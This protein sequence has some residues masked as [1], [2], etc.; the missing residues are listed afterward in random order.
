MKVPFV[1]LAAQYRELAPEIDEAISR[2]IRTSDFVLGKELLQFEEEFAEYCGV[3][4]AIGVDSGISALELSLRALDV[5]PGDEVITAANSFVA[6][7]SPITMVGA[8]PVL[9]DIDPR[10]YNLN[11]NTVV[12]A[13]TPKTKAIIPV[14]LYG[15]P[16][17]ID[18]LIKLAQ[19]RGIAIVEDACQA[20]GARYKG[21]RVGSLGNAAAFS[22]Y[23]AKNLGAY[24]D[25]GMIV[26][27]DSAVAEKVGMLRNYGQKVKY[28][29]ELIAFNHR[30]DTIQAAVLRVKLRHLDD[31][32]AARRRSAALYTQLLRHCDVHTPEEL[33]LIEHVYHLYVIRVRDRDA[34]QRYLAERGI[35]TGIHYP[36][37][38]HLQPAFR[39]LGYQEGDFPV[40]ERYAQEILSLPMY[41]GLTDEQIV[42]VVDAVRE[43]SA[44]PAV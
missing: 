20:H 36:I 23:P 1:D 35:A 16:V 43:S 9:V 21:R 3:R 15:Q 30:L 8:R 11:V 24:G 26:T 34:L 4:Y 31:W 40:T 25:G 14:H 10:T 12:D 39:D 42:D 2:V 22:F 6:S 18:P 19:A 29:H 41:P 7:A 33:N 5:G 27:N 17:D 13:V 37:P 32:N 44:V 28:H 38:I